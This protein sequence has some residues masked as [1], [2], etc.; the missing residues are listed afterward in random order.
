MAD[1]PMVGHRLDSAKCFQ[2]STEITDGLWSSVDRFG[3][4]FRIKQEKSPM[5][6]GP[7]VGRRLIRRSVSNQAREVA[8][9]CWAD[10]RASADSARCLNRPRE[11]TDG[12]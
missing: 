7:I 8:N 6:D 4:V 5:A 2:S 10:G 1:R 9:C 11:M 12:R 3:E